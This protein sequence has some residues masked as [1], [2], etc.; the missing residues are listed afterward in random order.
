MTWIEQLKYSNF[1]DD[2]D[3]YISC[4]RVVN[5]NMIYKD[6]GRYSEQSKPTKFY[7]TL[8]NFDAKKLLKSEKD[9]PAAGCLRSHRPRIFVE[10][11]LC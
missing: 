10:K 8:K 4:T 1:F 3:W 9:E 6:V 11:S 5:F 2:L 7:Q